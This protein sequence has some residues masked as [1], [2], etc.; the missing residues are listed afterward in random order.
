VALCVAE[1]TETTKDRREKEPEFKP[2]VFEIPSESLGRY[3]VGLNY[4]HKMQLTTRTTVLVRKY[5]V[6][7]IKYPISKLSFQS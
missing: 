6:F 7:L 1:L 2:G 3:R 5:A 4:Y